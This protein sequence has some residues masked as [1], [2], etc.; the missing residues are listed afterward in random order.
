MNYRLGQHV[1]ELRDLLSLW[2]LHKTYGI[3]FPNTE[4][5]LVVLFACWTVAAAWRH[6]PTAFRTHLLVAALINF[7]LYLAFCWP[8]EM[9]NLS[10]LV[11]SLVIVIATHTNIWEKQA[12]LNSTR[13]ATSLSC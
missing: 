3:M 10:M 11:P 1:H 8:G 2:H 4:N 5:I 6:L 12:C 9:R 13:G 7:P